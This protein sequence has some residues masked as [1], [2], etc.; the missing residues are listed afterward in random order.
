MDY[1]KKPTVIVVG[2]KKKD[3]PTKK[4]I[5]P[6]QRQKYKEDVHSFFVKR[7]KEYRFDTDG[8]CIPKTI[9]ILNNK[10]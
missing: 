6:I 9:D 7:T 3:A 1:S 10:K 2:K 4:K 5:T 8:T